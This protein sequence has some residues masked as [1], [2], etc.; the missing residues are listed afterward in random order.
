MSLL[1][2]DL[3]DVS[4]ILIFMSLFI[5][6][7]MDCSDILIF[8]T[9]WISPY[10]PLPALPFTTLENAGVLVGAHVQHFVEILSHTMY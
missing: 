10:P 6:D 9:F 3:M 7:L 5:F 8:W 4:D 1:I 2:F